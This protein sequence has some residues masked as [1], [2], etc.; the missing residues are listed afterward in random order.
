M[1]KLKDVDGLFNPPD[2]NVE[3]LVKQIFKSLNESNNMTVFNNTSDICRHCNFVL[4]KN[5]TNIT[6]TCGRCGVITDGIT[7]SE[8][9]QIPYSK[10]RI[11]GCNSSQFQSQIFKSDSHNN[12]QQL[13]TQ[14]RDEFAVRVNASAVSGRVIIPL[15][16]ISI[17]TDLYIK[18]PQSG[19]VKRSLNKLATMAGCLY[20]ACLSENYAPLPKDIATIMNL[21]NNGISKGLRILKD[22]YSKHS[23][24]VLNPDIEPTNALIETTFYNLQKC[25]SD[26]KIK[27]YKI[28]FDDELKSII[29]TYVL[30]LI[31]FIE[32]N[33]LCTSS[34]QR[35]KVIG[36]F[37]IILYRYR[38][39]CD[40]YR[41]LPLLKDFCSKL[42]IKP[43]TIVR[44]LD[45][46]TLCYET[47]DIKKY[48][49]EQGLYAEFDI[50][51][52]LLKQEKKK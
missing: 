32:L 9:D 23:I 46:F 37:Y 22:I 14:I 15:T 43:S 45:A 24:E 51:Y 52:K 3:T 28:E 35:T 40:I 8:L 49:I 20:I 41:S 7:E 6:N 42:S 31:N 2:E 27:S 38:D 4:E 1:S 19:I 29:K 30:N 5:I 21:N 39:N 26:P 12:S 13:H 33:V 36:S 44:F 17:A 50:N 11:V 18:L 10:I 47:A 16:T 25:D 48:F 34:N